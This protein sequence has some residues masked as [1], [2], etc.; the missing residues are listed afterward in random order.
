MIVNEELLG[1]IKEWKLEHK[2]GWLLRKIKDKIKTRPVTPFDHLLNVQFVIQSMICINDG[3]NYFFSRPPFSPLCTLRRHQTLTR[4]W[5]VWWRN[6]HRST[7]FRIPQTSCCGRI[8]WLAESNWR[9]TPPTT[10]C[11]WMP[12]TTLTTSPR[13]CPFPG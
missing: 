12:R 7:P 8:P 13:C 4:T 9:Q 3:V 1:L 10:R 11:S 5:S 6:C 2:K